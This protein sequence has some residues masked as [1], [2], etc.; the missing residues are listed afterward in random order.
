MPESAQKRIEKLR[1]EL[2]RHN[3]NY[4]VLSK[5]QISDQEFD[6]MMHELI[7]LETQHPDLLTPDSPSQRVGGE[8][9]DSFRSVEH[10]LRMMSIDN[11]YNEGELRAFDERIRKGL[12]G[13]KYKFVVEPKVDGVA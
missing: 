12:G 2:N 8:P 4:F 1:S 7:D 10:A 6:R 11:T 9:I 3:Y 13:Q 5:P